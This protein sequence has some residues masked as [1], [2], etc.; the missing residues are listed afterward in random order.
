MAYPRSKTAFRGGTTAPEEHL[1]FR[2]GSA[3]LLGGVSSR[4]LGKSLSK[5][6]GSSF[7]RLG[8]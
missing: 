5:P 1:S 3:P 2:P 4:R 7:Y 6:L 8:G